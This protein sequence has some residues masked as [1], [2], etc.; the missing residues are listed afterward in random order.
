[1]VAFVL[2]LKTLN[3]FGSSLTTSHNCRGLLLHYHI[4]FKYDSLFVKIEEEGSRRILYYDTLIALAQSADKEAIAFL[5]KIHTRFTR[6]S[7]TLS[8]QMIEVALS[9]A[10]AL[11]RALS[12]TE[13]VFYQSKPLVCD[14]AIK[15]KIY[16]KGQGD[17]F[18]AYFQ[19]HNREV[20]LE[21]CEKIFPSWCIWNGS[22]FPI[23]SSLSWRWM[24]L[25]IQFLD[26][27]VVIICNLK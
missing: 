18:S 26:R 7:S 16:W 27:V 17:K 8:F 12:K 23:D 9:H 21:S 14:W 24:E 22:A 10:S 20:P 15:A 2:I 6:L 25:F 4:S 13:R 19:Y 5:I 11:L 1:M 3:R